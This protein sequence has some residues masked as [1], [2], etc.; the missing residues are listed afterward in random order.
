M[1]PGDPSLAPCS[2]PQLQEPTAGSHHVHPE[3]AVAALRS[4]A[5]PSL[6]LDGLRGCSPGWEGTDTEASA[7]GPPPRTARSSMSCHVQRCLYLEARECSR[8]QSPSWCAR[9]A[10]HTFILSKPPSLEGE[11]L[12]RSQLTLEMGHPLPQAQGEPAPRLPPG[13]LLETDLCV[14][15]SWRHQMRPEESSRGGRT[16]LLP[17]G[18]VSKTE[19]CSMF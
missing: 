2:E 12:R 16:L 1:E 15:R 19:V 14:P 10:T 6:R 11:R 9:G 3:A 5:A 7:P 18:R 13:L 17:T 8:F 4:L